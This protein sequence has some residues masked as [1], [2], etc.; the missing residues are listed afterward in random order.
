METEQLIWKQVRVIVHAGL[1]CLC[2]S[3]TGARRAK[4]DIGL[5]FLVYAR[6]PKGYCAVCFD[7]A[8]GLY[9]SGLHAENLY[10][11]P[12]GASLVPFSVRRLT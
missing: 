3:L 2:A 8:I 10:P 5:S 6:V 11:K 12:A 9:G 7:P 4:R 1:R